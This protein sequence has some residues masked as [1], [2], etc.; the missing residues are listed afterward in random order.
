MSFILE[1][2]IKYIC[3]INQFKNP[4]MKKII[5]TAALSVLFATLTL[6]QIPF[7][8]TWMMK[9]SVMGTTIADY[10]SFDNDSQGQATNKIVIDMKMNIVGIKAV[11]KAEISVSGTFVTNGDKLTINWDLE[12]FT[13]TKTPVEMTYKGEPIED[14]KEEFAESLEEIVTEIKSDIEKN[15]VDEYFNVRVSGDKLSMSSLDEKGKKETEK[16][17]RVR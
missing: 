15:K 6:A 16:F 12:T 3:V 17:S 10:L 5:A 9:Q 1:R 14:G 4:V 2:K 7:T 8:G 11:G 13:V